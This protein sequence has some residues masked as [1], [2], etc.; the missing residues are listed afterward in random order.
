MGFQEGNGGI[1][2][3][4]AIHW[5]Y[6]DKL[7]ISVISHLRGMK[8]RSKAGE[9]A[10]VSQSQVGDFMS[11]CKNIFPIYER[12]PDYGWLV[13]WNIFLFSIYWE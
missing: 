9:Q 10:L 3:C 12:L 5:E 4:N 7:V 6:L 13:V 2:G 8:W 11:F 1:M